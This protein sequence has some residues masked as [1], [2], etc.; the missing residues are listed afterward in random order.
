M[1]TFLSRGLYV[2]LFLS[3]K[4]ISMMFKKKISIVKTRFLNGFGSYTYVFIVQ[5][6]F[7]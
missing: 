5:T 7:M 4:L 6:Q 3:L 2:T 1:V